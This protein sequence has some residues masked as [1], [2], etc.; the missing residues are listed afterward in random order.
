MA[1]MPEALAFFVSR[2]P[3]EGRQSLSTGL[4]MALFASIFFMIFG[5]FILPLALKSQGPVIV[6]DAQYT[7]LLIPPYLVATLPA[8]ALR[9]ANDYRRW[10]IARFA[11]TGGWFL[12]LAGVAALYVS[13]TL[14]VTPGQV[15][16]AFVVEMAL[17]AVPIAVVT[18]RRLEGPAGPAWGLVRPLT[19]FGVPA[20]F[21][22]FPQWLNLRMDQIVIAGFLPARQLGLYAVAVAW[23]QVVSPVLSAL[24]SMVLPRLAR[25]TDLSHRSEMFAHASRLGI[26]LGVIVVVPTVAVTPFVIQLLFGQAF[27]GSIPSALLLVFGGGLLGLN[28]ILSEALL[29]S[30]LPSGPM[31]AQLLGLVVTG[32]TLAAFL[33]PLGIFGAAISSVAGYGT[34]TLWLL[35]EGKRLNQLNISYL[36]I[37]GRHEFALLRPRWPSR[38][39]PEAGD[40]LDETPATGSEGR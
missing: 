38:K 2:N 18:Y 30:G 24:G 14:R 9:G 5:V 20:M 11:P 35:I 4:L 21:A 13:G 40:G 31:R 16:G 6:R 32:I 8:Q 17:L 1:G 29:G 37:P 27:I 39:P 28:Y 7:L 36:V 33:A 22:T 10:N 3:K 26:L 34:T 19:R 12:I 15:A 25:E 23:A